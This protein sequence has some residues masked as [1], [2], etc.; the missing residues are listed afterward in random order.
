MPGKLVNHYREV[1]AK[2]QIRP[3][4]ASSEECPAEIGKW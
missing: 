1:M 3:Q 2:S 4:D